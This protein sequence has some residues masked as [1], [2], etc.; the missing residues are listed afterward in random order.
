MSQHAR[1]QVFDIIRL[2]EVA[3]LD[4]CICLTGAIERECPSWTHTK[5]YGGMVARAPHDCQQ[6]A[7]Y[8]WLPLHITNSLL[9]T[10][11]LFCISNRCQG[12]EWFLIFEAMQDSL[13]LFFV[14]ITHLHA[15][16]EAVE[17][18]FWQRKSTFE[19]NRVLC[20]DY[21]R[22]SGQR[23]RLALNRYL[24]FGHRF[25]QRRLCAWS[26]SVYLINQQDLREYGAA[27]KNKFITFLIK[28]AHTNN[29]CWK[30]VRCAL[31][32]LER[33]SQRTC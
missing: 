14:G 13:L 6:V 22:W 7:F 2:Y 30:K 5:L 15:Q 4:G 9:H 24:P 29:I 23:H 3:P 16:Q 32:A 17:L 31:Y 1:C 12:C 8:F 33:G 21:E 26:G 25:Q 18:C 28:I 11:N 27:T 20:R 10:D 19:L